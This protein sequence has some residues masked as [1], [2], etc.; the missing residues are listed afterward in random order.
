ML[1]SASLWLK[2]T[3]A[4]MT[5]SLMMVSSSA[6]AVSAFTLTDS[7]V[8][9]G[10]PVSA[11]TISP[12][13][14]AAIYSPSTGVLNNAKATPSSFKPSNGEKTTIHFELVGAATVWLDIMQNGATIKRLYNNAGVHMTGG[15]YDTQWNG[16]NDGGILVNDGTYQ[17]VV[18]AKLDATGQTFTAQDNI[19][20][21]SNPAVPAVTIS[22]GNAS[23]NPF[24]PALGQQTFVSYTLNTQANLNIEVVDGSTVLTQLGASPFT[25]NAGTYSI[26]WNGK[27]SGSNV[28][29]KTYYIRF[30]GKNDA[31][32]VPYVTTVP[33]TVDY[34]ST[35]ADP[36]VQYVYAEN[37]SFNPTTS[38]NR[39]HYAVDK[40]AVAVVKILN[41]SNSV[42]RT[43]A[44]S[45]VTS[46]FDYF[47]N[48]DG[49]SDSNALVPAGNYSAKVELSLTSG[50]AV[51]DSKQSASFA[52]D[53][54]STNNTAP[55]VSSVSVNPS[56]FNPTNGESTTVSYTLDK[57]ATSAKVEIWDGSTLRRTISAGT[58]VGSNAVTFNG[59]DDSNNI[60]ANGTYTVKVSAT[61]AYGTGSNTALVTITSSGSTN[62]A[63]V[64]TSVYVNP[65]SFNPSNSESTTVYYTLDKVATSARVEIWDGSTLRRTIN[66]TG[67]SMSTNSVNFNGRDDN[68]NIL[69]NGTYTVKVLATNAYGTGSNTTTVTVTSNGS[70]N[71]TSI[72]GTPNL[73]NVY[74]SP[75]T[76]NPN[77]QSVSVY[78]TLD[79]SANVTVEVLNNNS[80]LIRTLSDNVCRNNGSNSYNWDGRDQYGN[81][82]N[83]GSYTVRV[84]ANNGSGTDTEYTY[85]T[86]NRNGSTNNNGNLILNL[87]V[88]PEIFN[89]RQGQTSTAYYNLNQTATVTTQVLDRNGIVIRTLVDNITRY[90]NNYAYST[91]YGSY[92]YG[93][94]WNGRDVN[95][96]IVPDNIYQFRVTANGNGQT[97]TKTAWVEVDTD[98]II[99]GFPNGST[100]GGYIDVSSNSP[101]CKA[102]LLMRD[103][104]V[105]SGYT[106]GTFRPYQP[107]NRAETV[108]VILL[109]LSIPVLNDGTT[110]FRDTDGGA[111]YAPYLR[112]AK[113][114]GIIRG[115][116]DGTFR[117]NQTVNRVE[118]LKVFL[119]SSGVNIPYCNYA[120][121]N[122]TPVN[123]DTRWYIDYACYAK[124]N[125]LMHDD[126]TGRFS[127]AAAMTRGDV[128]DLFYQFE[129]RGL[130]NQQNNPY[131]N[132]TYPYGYNCYNYNGSYNSNCYNNNY[133]NNNGCY[134]NGVYNYNCY[135][136]NYNNNNN[137]YPMIN[138]INVSPATINPYNQSATISYTLNNSVNSATVSI[139]DNNSAVRRTFYSAGTSTSGNSVSFNGRDDNGNILPRGTYTARVTVTNN[140]G[141]TTA[142]TYVY[143]QY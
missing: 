111:W 133:N 94:Q 99:I 36:K 45:S 117:P 142:T 141:S 119:E 84:R 22:T 44:S 112:T 3:V 69:A 63:P 51:V 105:F 50:G 48:W 13:L 140:V 23:P 70:G 6:Q 135:N 10:T 127:P 131:L 116:P 5:L 54:G 38:T 134:I 41:A 143:L 74:A 103:N 20:V 59:R 2:K 25:Q 110:L 31:T 71:C 33:V 42:V 32:P 126:G 4:V 104:G 8:T 118:L 83:D 129:T 62:S 43:Y 55:V 88:Q 28:A 123:G 34:G 107:I 78:Y 15:A 82:V 79:R 11:T 18:S 101:Y 61:N 122:D 137:G 128:A 92:N 73:T 24:N 102:I 113:R 96:N 57:A 60:L 19:I 77:N 46:G 95:G 35:A 108:K 76:F 16:L 81:M 26:S 89:P 30:T 47:L 87:Y 65:T 9:S 120:P 93:D 40:S 100:C 12:A 90:S 115:Y 58:N 98:G 80:T 97:D 125:G 29:A 132:G 75:S 39:I 67:T 66:N 138:S 14:L 106:D 130:Y 64:V 86:V 49:R 85:V 109:A 7:T 114:L 52:V 121:Y 21:T 27:V 139:L 1:H 68:G 136:N 56:S 124:S 53:Y 72:S 91:S 17:F 37:G